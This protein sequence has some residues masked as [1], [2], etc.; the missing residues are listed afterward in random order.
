MSSV[1]TRFAPSPT[2][3]LHIGSART[4]LFSW[5]YAR[6]HNGKF[7]LRVEDTD[8][9]RYSEDAVQKI[10]ESMKWLGLD[11]D[12]P[13]VSQFEQRGRHVEVAEEMLAHGHAYHCYCSQDEISAMREKAKTEGKPMVYDGTCR[14]RTDVPEGIQPVIRLKAPKDGETTIEDEVQGTITLKNSELDDLILVRSDGTPTYMLAVVVDDHD[15]GVTHIIRGDDHL[16]N[17]T[18]QT[19]I[20]QAM[21]WE[22]PVFA[23]VPLIHGPDGAK[24]SKR[25][26]AMGA[27]EYRDMG[28]LPEAMRN[29][30]ARLGWSHGDDELFSTEQ[31]IEWFNLESIGKSPARFDFAKLESVNAH[32]IRQSDEATLL[33]EIESLFEAEALPFGDSTRAQLKVLLPELR[34][35]AKTLHNLVDGSRFIS[36][37]RPLTMDEKAA[38]QLDEAAKSILAKL[39]ENLKHLESWTLE[40]IEDAVRGFVEKEELKFGK[41]GQPLRAALSG[42][43]QSPGI[44]EILLVLGQEESIA[45]IADQ[46]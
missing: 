13:P 17:A 27:E 23:H 28:Y 34:K 2:G 9:N 5:L 11:W 36:Q 37:S 8:R 20:Y 25:H 24:L 31:A 33:G 30:L 45:R 41:V 35:R 10:Y 15:M 4:A 42:T 1:V 43:T 39:S 3:Y 14:E 22:V 6:K 26:G 46:C 44:F 7:L 38:K 16:T 21:N 18:R 12:G 29:Y 40:S 19:L 32:W